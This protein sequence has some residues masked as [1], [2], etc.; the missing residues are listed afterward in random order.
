MRFFDILGRLGLG[1]ITDRYLY[2]IRGIDTATKFNDYKG[3]KKKLAVV[4][5]SPALLKVVS[6]Q[7][8]LFSLGEV[9]VYDK[10]KQ[11]IEDDPFLKL[12]KKPNPFQSKSQ[13]LWDYM[14]WQ[15]LGTSN[16]YADSAIVEK[17]M[18]RLYFLMPH[19]I[20]WPRKLQDDSDKLV[21]SDASIKERGK[22]TI[23]Y[24]YNDN[25]TFTFPLDR[26]ITMSDL[27]N[28]VGNWYK[29]PSRIDALYKIISNSE[30]AL[31]AKNINVRFSGKFL[32]GST[33][34]GTSS[35]G[36]G[37]EEK[38]DITEKIESTKKVW[39]LKTMVQ[40]RRFVE[41]MGALKLD[42]AYLS[43]YF[44]IGSMVN[45]PRD[46]LEAYVS[47][48]FEN[49]EKARMAHVSYTLQPKGNDFFNSLEEH[50][51]YNL[52]G[53][54]IYI[55]WSHLPFMQVFEKEKAE[56]QKTKVETFK[57]MIALGI[58]VENANKYLDTD[59]EIEEKPQD[60][61]QETTATTDTGTSEEV[62]TSEGE[63]S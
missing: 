6:L 31:D 45:I 27:T 60:N 19:K 54:N 21:F 53:K 18:N 22:T 26:L 34:P 32:V 3:D 56:V 2:S 36:L 49:Q 10:Q 29:S 20:E 13:F 48:T 46:V 28:G 33:A 43:D 61:E 44:L 4:L 5:S 58:S 23:T 41:D 7:C 25:T 8:D 52:E 55:D 57:N 35:F 1:N 9:F 51:G 38:D 42:E 12:I 59:F 37:Q 39:P 17:P 16:L 14:F 30:H 11:V 62:A 47:S 15:M 50:F 40:I 24:R 63:E